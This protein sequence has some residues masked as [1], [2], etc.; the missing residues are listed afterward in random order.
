MGLMN[1]SADMI[2]EMEHVE[3]LSRSYIVL[4]PARLSKIN[5]LS[6]LISVAINF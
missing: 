1:D 4:T 2:D 3:M 6:T 5:L